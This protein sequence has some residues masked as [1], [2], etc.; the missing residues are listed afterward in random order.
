M[1]SRRFHQGG[2]RVPIRFV[3]THGLANVAHGLLIAAL[4]ILF[5]Y[6]AGPIVEPLAIA[7]LLS[8]ILAPVMR[9]LRSRGAP[10]VVA[11]IISVALTLSVLGALGATL[12]LQGRQLAQDLPTYETNLREKIKLLGNMPFL[13]PTGCRS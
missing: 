1:E 2:G 13:N 9:R 12:G 3:N 7:A 10:K 4:I 8:F 6:V 11:A 5:L